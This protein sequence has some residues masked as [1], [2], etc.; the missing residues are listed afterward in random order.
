MENESISKLYETMTLQNQLT[1]ITGINIPEF[2]G[3]PN[4]DVT[5]FLKKFKATTFAL[6]DELKCIALRKALIGSARI[7]AK[8]NLKDLISAGKWKEIKRS[9]EDRFQPADYQERYHKKLATMKYD[10][11][12]TTLRSYVEGYAVCYRK[13]HNDCS[14]KN[15]IESLVQNLPS[16]IKHTLNMLSETWRQM[17]KMADLYPIIKR[18]EQT[19]IPYEPKPIESGEKLNIDAMAKLLKDM[20]ENFKKDCLA[21]VQA[22][23]KVSNDIAVAA[24]AQFKERSSRDDRLQPVNKRR[25]FQDYNRNNFGR[26]QTNYQNRVNYQ[27][28]PKLLPQPST[29]AKPDVNNN[30]K[31]NEEINPEELKAPYYQKYGKPPGPCWNCKG[32]HFNRHCPYITL[33]QDGQI[34]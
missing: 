2:S 11:K 9:I 34:E 17:D 18:V 33:N 26:N 25:R 31:S 5:E 1:A 23:T 12:V 13:A 21:A 28:K 29:N 3:S 10:P 24:I 16:N 15:I 20:Q 19:I 6:N 14:D 27:P 22:Q 8:D 32:D 7:W 30:P 4:E